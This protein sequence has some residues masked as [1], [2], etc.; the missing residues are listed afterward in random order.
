MKNDYTKDIAA[1][2][3]KRIEQY[4][5]SVSARQVGHVL[6]VADGVARV[7]GLPQVASMERVEF[8]G[9]VAGLAFNLEEDV[10]GVI[11][12]GDYLGIHEGDEV[13][14]TGKLLSMP[15]GNGFLGRVVNPLGEPVDGAAAVKTKDF[16]PIE[17]IA[18]SVTSR[19]S[20]KTPLQTGIKAI[21]AMIPIGRGQREL[22]I[23]DRNT[24]KT[25]VVV[26]TIINQ[27]KEGVICIYVA[28]GQKTSRVAQVIHDLTAAGAMSHTIVITATASDSAAYQY[29]APYAGTAMGEY[30]MDQGKDALIIYDDLSKHAWAYRQ[31]SLVLRRPS[32]REA[33]PGDVF[34]LHSRLLERSCRLDEKHGGGS[35]TALPIVE[36]QA[37]DISGY[38]PTNVISITDGQLF[39]ES[40]LFNA[41]QRPA[42]NVGFSV[43]RVGGEAQIKA[44]KKVSGTLKLDL[45]QYRSLAAFAQFSSDVDEVTKKQI[46]RGARM[47]ELLKQGQGV[48][49]PVSHQI[50]SIWSGT[51]G[52]L[53]DVAVSDVNRFEKELLTF[54]AGRH[55]KVFAL[56]EKEK[57]MTPEIETMLKSAVTEFKKGF[58]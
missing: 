53:D 6:S 55:K 32:G 19:R 57:N 35:L 3:I 58:K 45:A 40:D 28:I 44:M 39:L 18:P 1:E 10:V 7:S 43:S 27:K 52:Y 16:Y 21:D 33:Y 2:L 29:L 4:T 42:I 9:G 37:N 11:V 5:P 8:A 17:K 23:G 56:I 36:T 48:P 47:M 51:A 38:I 46:D 54:V 13:R 31:I 22:I 24:G 25:T 41:G 12:L 49:M 34:Y 30:F 15:V 26:D 20:V 50:V 14:S